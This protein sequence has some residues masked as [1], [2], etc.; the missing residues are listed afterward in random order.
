MIDVCF[1]QKRVH[2]HCSFYSIE[3]RA[4]T[5]SDHFSRP[6]NPTYNVFLFLS[7][8][9]RELSRFFSLSNPNQTIHSTDPR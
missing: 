7:T 6:K 3:L 9:Q 8:I 1:L 2:I 4:S 5:N